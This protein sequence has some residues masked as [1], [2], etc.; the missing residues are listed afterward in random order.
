MT[1]YAWL[2][3]KFLDGNPLSTESNTLNCKRCQPLRHLLCAVLT[4]KFRGF[5][6]IAANVANSRSIRDIQKLINSWKRKGLSLSL[7]RLN[8]FA[9]IPG[10]TTTLN[11]D[12]FTMITHIQLVRNT[13]VNHMDRFKNCINC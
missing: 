12:M 10:T 4:M 3:D 5:G 7:L 9:Q 11:S 2:D 13:E 8:F 6:I 1:F